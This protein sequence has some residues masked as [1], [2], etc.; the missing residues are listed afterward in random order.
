V[1]CSAIGSSIRK[2]RLLCNLGLP[3]PGKVLRRLRSTGFA[4]HP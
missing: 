4:H 2:S 3:T 1:V